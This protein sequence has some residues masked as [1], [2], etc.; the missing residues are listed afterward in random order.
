MAAVSY[1]EKTSKEFTHE[2]I[3]AETSDYEDHSFCGVMFN[4]TVSAGDLPVDCFQIEEIW[5]RGGLGDMKIFVSK[6]SYKNKHNRSSE[7]N[8]IYNSF[9][10][11]S[12]RTLE[13]LK[14]PV[15]LKV[16]TDET[17][18]LYIHSSARNDESV[19]YDNQ[20]GFGDVTLKD[21]FISVST[22][23]AHLDCVP[24]GDHAPWGGS[25]WRQRRSFVGRITYGVRYQLWNPT[26]HHRF[27]LDFRNA[28]RALYRA[29]VFSW[30]GLPC[31]I[32][33]YILNMCPHSWFDYERTTTTSGSLRTMIMNPSAL[34][35]AITA[36][37]TTSTSIEDP[38]YVIV[39]C[40]RKFRCCIS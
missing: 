5:V 16:N 34:I 18:G 25:A 23:F 35:T 7:W 11:P 21:K 17:I 1:Y 33:Q 28:C 8:L 9:H 15:P 6:G 27:P 3:T 38:R 19:V 12:F 24:F 29:H 2:S 22:A 37:T 30:N 26:N 14:L 10:G 40:L 31:D 13:K 32:I 20:R 39:K 36:A 4:L